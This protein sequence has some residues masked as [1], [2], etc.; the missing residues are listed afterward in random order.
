MNDINMAENNSV[1]FVLPK[2]TSMVRD[3]ASTYVAIGNEFTKRYYQNREA[4]INNIV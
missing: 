3:Y 1:G 2:A 4:Y